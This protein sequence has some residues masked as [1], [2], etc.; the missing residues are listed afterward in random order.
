[1]THPDTAKLINDQIALELEKLN[2]FMT[3]A[4]EKPAIIQRIADLKAMLD[5]PA[6]DMK[7]SELPEL[8][9]FAVDAIRAWRSRR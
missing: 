5:G 7:P 8:K 4:S 2:D 1:M 6:G 3:F 9:T